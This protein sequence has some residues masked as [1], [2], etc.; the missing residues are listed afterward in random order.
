[1]ATLTAT[2]LDDLSRVRLEL[3]G[4]TTGVS[5]RIERSTDGGA[6]W[7]P[8]RGAQ[9]MSTLTVAIVDDFEFTPNVEN[10]YRLIAP[11]FAD[12][13]SRTYPVG[14]TLQLD[15]SVSSYA[16]TPDNAALDITGDIDIRVDFAAAQW[17]PAADQTLIAKYNGGT[18]NRSYRVDIRTTGRI[19]FYWSTNGTNFF[20]LTSSIPVAAVQNQRIA[21][22][23]AFDA[24][25]GASGRT[26]TFYTAYWIGGTW[27][28]LG[29]PVTSA[30]ATSIFSSNAVLEVGSRDS[31]TVGRFNG[32]VFGAQVL[33]SVSATVANPRFYQQAP[34]TTSFADSATRTW[35]VQA[36]ADIVEYAPM[37]GIDWGTADSGQNWNLGTSSVG[38]GNFVVTGTGVLQDEDVA[39]TSSWQ[40]TDS[41]PGTED[42]EALWSALYSDTAADLDASVEWGLGLRGT[43]D[44]D[45]YESNLIMRP[46]GDGYAVELRLGKFVGGVFTQISTTN[47]IGTWA[48]D[49]PWR[50]RFRV[51]GS[52]LLARAWEHGTNEP[53]DW[54]LSSTDT[55]IVTG[56]QIVVR[57]AKTSGVRYR[58]YFGPISVNTVPANID[59]T[60]AV[61]PV[62]E[63][64]WLKSITYPMFNRP[65]DCVDW[66]ELERTSRTSFFDIKG[67]HE[68]LG[69]ADVGSTATFPLTFI[70]R[71]KAENLAIVA[72]LTYGGLMLLQPQGD[73]ED[74]ACPTLYS[75]IP[76]GYVMVGDSTQSRTVYGQPIWLWTVQFTEV[77]PTDATAVL[78]TTIT[79]AQLWD[80]I[81]PDGTWETV[82]D[83]W[84]TWQQMWLA[85]GNPLAFGG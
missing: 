63:D 82:W 11:V 78:P 24:D 25:N 85:Q 26:A 53:M 33:N 12:S 83:T 30:T 76:E 47:E 4:P 14:A 37:I 40:Y 38:F 29:D 1:M 75:G 59:I 55:D 31:G 48:R 34:G 73:N 56:D 21:V 58:Q 15:G 46:S 23:V 20:S 81:G 8:V 65:L 39:G 67:R 44:D 7:E 50:V 13:F 74:E 79:W 5:Y 10:L 49:I 2:Y 61:T 3:I 51:N 32:K 64:V 45:Y 6:T 22:R 41:I 18:N 27:A 28:Q 57:G 17:P 66:E 52:T 69:V 80:I 71:S 72:L 35:T 54:Q 19:T 43:G 16:S 9:N 60:V 42:A 77:A 84:P 36:N 62:Q 68:R 70:S